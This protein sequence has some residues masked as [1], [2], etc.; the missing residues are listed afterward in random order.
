MWFVLKLKQQTL[1]KE[2]GG[3]RSTPGERDSER[4]S[5]REKFYSMHL[6]VRDSWK[7]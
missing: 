6:Y 1:L 7:V 5:G 3:G 2:G 4:K